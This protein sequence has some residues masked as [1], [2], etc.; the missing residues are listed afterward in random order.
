MRSGAGDKVTA[1]PA[2]AG[3]GDI[4]VGLGFD[5]GQWSAT[6]SL[7]PHIFSERLPHTGSHFSLFTSFFLHASLS[8]FFLSFQPPS[9]PSLFPSHVE[10][11]LSN[12]CD[13]FRSMQDCEAYISG[14][15][16][17]RTRVRTRAVAGI[18]LFATMSRSNSYNV[19]F[20][21]GG[22]GS[23]SGPRDR[24]FSPHLRG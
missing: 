9:I 16:P 3:W 22:F 18:F 11:P 10:D 6:S 7:T 17:G 19:C 5:M 21:F 13:C 20:V 14:Y 15:E 2:T 8:H 24:L 12:P 1:S 4:L 23:K